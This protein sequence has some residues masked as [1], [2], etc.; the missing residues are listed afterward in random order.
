MFL[1]TTL[2]NVKLLYKLTFRQVS[3]AGEV[4]DHNVYSRWC[5][6]YKI[7]RQLDS[8]EWFKKQTVLKICDQELLNEQREVIKH[9]AYE[10]NS[11]K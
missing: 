1:F 6:R 3:K 2:F 4:R 7:I 5:D 11:F 10:I 9:K 8:K